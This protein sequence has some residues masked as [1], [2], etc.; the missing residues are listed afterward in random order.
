MEKYLYFAK[1]SAS[2]DGHE[3][4]AL[5]PSSNLRAIVGSLSNSSR[6]SNETHVMIKFDDIDGTENKSAFINIVHAF[7]D[8]KKVC[9]SIVSLINGGRVKSPFI[10]AVDMKNGVIAVEGCT[11]LS[12]INLELSE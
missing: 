9:R 3:D 2:L 11:D 8:K 6:V 5:V 1:G 10:Q 7:G 12:S 4:I